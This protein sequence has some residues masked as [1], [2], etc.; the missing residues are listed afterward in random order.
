ME[1]RTAIACA[2]MRMPVLWLGVALIIAK[3]VVGDRLGTPWSEVLAVLGA[4]VFLLGLALYLRI[5]TIRGEPVPLDAPVSGRWLAL[6]SPARRVPSHGTHAY[7]QTYAVDMAHDP[8]DGSRPAF[9]W[10][11]LARRAENFPA[12]GQPVLAPADGTVVRV[13]DR[14]RDHWSRNSWPALL[15]VLVEAAL[16]ECLGP[17]RIL[18]NH[19]VIDIGEGRY[20]ALAH[21]R[22]GSIR[23]AEG[24]PVTAGERLASCGNSGNST[25][26]H[27]HFQLMDRPN[28]L[29]AAGLPFRFARY[30][31][32]EGVHSG[33]PGNG[34]AFVAPSVTD[35]AVG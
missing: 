18:G 25:E 1:P 29:F 21:L 10:W 19:V 4:V 9:D 17:G 24:D 32:D 2:R 26:P 14:E 34:Q 12:F 27:L 33:V 7:G 31:T 8:A 5:G 20:V 15:Y 22:R 16:R 6:N 35:S 11:P 30:Q 13:H 28:V 3:L 23:V